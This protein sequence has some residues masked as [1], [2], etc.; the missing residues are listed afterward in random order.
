VIL[1]AVEH[2][3]PLKDEIWPLW[4]QHYDEIAEDKASVPLDPDWAK[5]DHLAET[6][7]LHI[8]TARKDGVLV[9]YAFN[10]VS[11]HLHYRTTLFA[12]SDLYWLKPDCR[13]GKTAFRF[14]AFVEASLAERG[15]TKAVTNVKRAHDQTSR[16]FE[17]LGWRH[18]E[19][20]YVKSI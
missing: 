12:F 18:A 10:I 6:G 17:W 15:V 8:V 20:L 4:Q 14:F 5:Y 9:G 11:T 2:W 7:C 13:G 1:F 3:E 16:L 19:R